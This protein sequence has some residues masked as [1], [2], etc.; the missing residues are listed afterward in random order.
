MCTPHIIHLDLIILNL[1]RTIM[2]LLTEKVFRPS[3]TVI[4]STDCSRIL[5]IVYLSVLTVLEK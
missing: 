2:K 3:I 1:V 4:S 5:R